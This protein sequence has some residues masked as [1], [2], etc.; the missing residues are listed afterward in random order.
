MSARL[1]LRENPCSTSRCRLVR[2]QRRAR[3]SDY[4][5]VAEK[6]GRRTCL[7]SKR[8]LWA[9]WFESSL[10]DECMRGGAG[11]RTSLR[12]WRPIVDMEVRPLSHAL[13][14]G[15]LNRQKHPSQTR[16]SLGS[17]PRPETESSSPTRSHLRRS[18]LPG[19]GGLADTQP[20][21]SDRISEYRTTKIRRDLEDGQGRRYLCRTI[22]PARAG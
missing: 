5:R 9:C 16:A 22:P 21:E 14:S 4:P 1:V 18:K 3:V 17:S 7:R 12:C 11:I 2:L 8:S 15:S 19:V 13:F 20:R 6:L 10:G